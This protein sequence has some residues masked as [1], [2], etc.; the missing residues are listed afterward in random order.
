M[1]LAYASQPSLLELVAMEFVKEFKEKVSGIRKSATGNSVNVAYFAPSDGKA[2]FLA[3]LIECLRDQGFLNLASSVQPVLNPDRTLPILAFA[4]GMARLSEDQLK[5]LSR[6]HDNMEAQREAKDGY[7]P[8][9]YRHIAGYFAHAS[10]ATSDSAEAG[11]L[12]MLLSSISREVLELKDT[13]QRHTPQTVGTYAKILAEVVSSGVTE[14]IMEKADQA[15]RALD[16]LIEGI[17][18]PNFPLAELNNL[19]STL[20]TQKD[21]FVRAIIVQ[22][23]RVAKFAQNKIQ[24]ARRNLG[25]WR[26]YELMC[27]EALAEPSSAPAQNIGFNQ[28]YEWFKKDLHR[29]MDTYEGISD[30]V[31]FCVKERAPVSPF[32]HYV[33]N[34]LAVLIESVFETKV[35]IEDQFRIRLNKMLHRCRNTLK[36]LERLMTIENKELEQSPPFIQRR[37]D[38]LNQEICQVLA[39]GNPKEIKYMGL[40]FNASYKNIGKSIAAELL[41]EG[42]SR[43]I[44]KHCNLFRVRFSHILRT[45]TSIMHARVDNA[46]AS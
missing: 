21:K 4:Q 32:F 31:D 42:Q 13:I 34:D 17:R 8:T 35:A 41:K 38:Y 44:E 43:D 12:I 30:R 28:H 45:A 46:K 40:A 14:K 15:R 7:F 9:E 33:L 10:T 2:G 18:F 16:I 5:R 23:G 24:E 37:L 29:Q 39:R 22:A 26:D 19:I 36:Q 1:V 20:R 11:R 3:D 6:F 25:A 27:V